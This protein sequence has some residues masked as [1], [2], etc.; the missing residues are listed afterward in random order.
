VS[1]FVVD[2]RVPTVAE[3]RLL[4]DAVGWHDLPADDAAVARGLAASLFG[5]CVI[6]DGETIACGRVIGDGAVYFYLQDVMVKP[7]WQGMGAGRLV[8][9]AIEGYL[10]RAAPDGA[11]VGLMAAAGKAGFYERFG[12]AARPSDEPGM[13][14]HWRG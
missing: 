1:G 3:L 12:F 6:C 2:E 10:R 5:V 11:F 14:R 7:D 8:L 9:E 13:A 4:N